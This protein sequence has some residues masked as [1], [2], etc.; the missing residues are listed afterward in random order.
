M[1][2]TDARVRAFITYVLKKNKS[3]TER[4]VKAATR[5]GLKLGRK[6]LNARII[7][8]VRKSLGIDRPRAIAHAKKLLEKNPVLEAKLVIAELAERFG[9]SVG[10]PDV[11]RLRPVGARR[12]KRR[13]ARAKPQTVSGAQRS[14]GPIS[15]TYVA[16]GIPEDVAQFFRALAE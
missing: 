16:K 9:V 14:N 4:E 10:P 2:K 11:S 6:P 8:N 5:R 7:R 1:N 12:V 13:V 15:V 3:L